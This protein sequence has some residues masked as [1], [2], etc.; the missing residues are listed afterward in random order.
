[1]YYYLIIK[2]K[3]MNLLIYEKKYFR[4]INY[5]IDFEDKYNIFKEKIVE[6]VKYECTTIYIYMYKQMIQI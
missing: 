4:K 2:Y 6:V 1:M 5:S 3:Y